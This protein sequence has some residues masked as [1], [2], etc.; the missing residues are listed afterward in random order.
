MRFYG[1]KFHEVLSMDNGTFSHLCGSMEKVLAIEKLEAFQ[2]VSFPNLKEDEMK[3]VHKQTYKDA[4]TVD[5]VEK[6]VV[7]LGDIS[8]MINGRS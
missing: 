5:N 3:R 7:K 8:R 1:Y 4:E 2:V 6:N